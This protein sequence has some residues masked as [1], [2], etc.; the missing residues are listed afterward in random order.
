MT[1]R[2]NGMRIGVALALAAGVVAARPQ[3]SGVRMEQPT[4]S[5]KVHVYYR[6]TGE[7][8][9]VTMAIETNAAVAPAWS[10][11]RI[12]DRFVT[13]LTGDVACR[14]TADAVNEKQI[15][16]DARADWPDQKLDEARA[17]IEVWTR[18]KLPPVAVLDLGAAYDV[19]AHYPL[20]VY[21]SVEGLPDGGLTNDIYRTRKL[22]L[23]RIPN[24][25]YYMGSP[26][27]ELGKSVSEAQP[28]AGKE[29]QHLVSLTHDYYIGVFEVTQGQWQRVMDTNPSFNTGPA[30]PPVDVRPVDRVSFDAIRGGTWP[31]P[32]DAV[33]AE[34]F[35]GRLRA[36]SDGLLFDLPTEAQ[37]EIACRAG[38][39]TALN[40]GKPLTTITALCPNRNEIAWDGFNA[41]GRHHRVGEKQPNAWGLYDMI[42]NVCETT[43]DRFSLSLGYG[44]ASDP[45]GGT[46]ESDRVRKGGGFNNQAD[47]RSAVRYRISPATQVDNTGFRIVLLTEGTPAA[48]P[49]AQ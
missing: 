16:W 41:G 39:L 11:V 17:V 6:L 35:V 21:N 48:T 13:R 10:G 4:G 33:G 1:A 24:G 22:V 46:T 27:N 26:T 5:R 31:L 7:D 36:K 20:H 9:Y 12:P 47:P 19:N 40:H 42:G 34:S 15:V 45:V 8:A 14:V 43:R 25:C 30:A 32:G 29:R 23:R 37:W 49:P 2:S 28:A 18:D 3:I 44:W 38:T